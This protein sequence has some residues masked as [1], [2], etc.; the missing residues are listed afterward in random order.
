M[1]CLSRIIF[2]LFKS[3]SKFANQSHDLFSWKCCQQILVLRQKISQ[4]L[5]ANSRNLVKASCT[6]AL[7]LVDASQGVQA[8]TVANFYLAFSQGLSLLPVINKV[9][10]PSAEP[11]RALEQ[12]KDTFEL[13]YVCLRPLVFMFALPES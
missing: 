11:E 6:G 3:L 1:V 4:N 12:I 10:L 9:D 8:Q 13:E 5:D 2:S 7:L